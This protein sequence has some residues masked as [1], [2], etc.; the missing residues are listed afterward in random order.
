M[1]TLSLR[2]QVPLRRVNQAYVIA[3]STSIDVSGV[4]SSKFDDAYFKAAE[5]KTAKKGESEFFESE[6]EKKVW[7]C[8]LMKAKVQQSRYVGMRRSVELQGG[9]MPRIRAG[10]LWVADPLL[11][12][13]KQAVGF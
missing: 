4:D 1:L 5:K 8:W 6:P 7:C 3:T 10:C 9:S 12:Y 11:R 13:S 2:A